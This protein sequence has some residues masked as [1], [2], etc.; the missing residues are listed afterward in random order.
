MRK[1]LKIAVMAFAVLTVSTVSFAEFLGLL[2]VVTDETA[3]FRCDVVA[4]GSSSGP[5]NA[6]VDVMLKDVD[7]G[8]VL[9]EVSSV[10]LLL[11]E[12]VTVMA[13]LFFTFPRPANGSVIACKIEAD[14]ES[15]GGSDLAGVAA[16]MTSLS[17]FGRTLD[18]VN[19]R[20]LF[21][22]VLKE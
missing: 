1:S 7:T 21:D 22:R 6:V 3:V 2:L 4:V 15:S 8:T 14:S 12:K 11:H 9:D 10:E 17:G 16:S 5:P 20:T 13:N 19:D 18:V